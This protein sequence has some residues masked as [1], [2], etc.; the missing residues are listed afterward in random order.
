MGNGEH[1][2]SAGTWSSATDPPERG[3]SS[4]VSAQLAPEGRK[5]P[6]SLQSSLGNRGPAGRSKATPCVSWAHTWPG[7]H[8]P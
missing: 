8:R 5:G 1:G 4:Q 6:L 3:P 2:A 7:E